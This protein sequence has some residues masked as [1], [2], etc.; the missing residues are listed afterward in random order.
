MAGTLQSPSQIKNVYDKLVF[1]TS[2][3]DADTHEIYMTDTALGQDQQIKSLDINHKQLYSVSH[4][5]QLEGPTLAFNMNQSTV[6]QTP[7]GAIDSTRGL[8]IPLN[9]TIIKAAIS[10]E[11]AV[12]NAGSWVD[13]GI[14]VWDNTN[15]GENHLHANVNKGYERLNLETPGNDLDSYNQV[16]FDPVSSLTLDSN[17]FYRGNSI[18]CWWLFENVDL[19]LDFHLLTRMSVL[20]E[21]DA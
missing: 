9:G 8:F 14:S 10:I 1:T 11:G 13:F 2:A 5:G 4:S 3:V 21:F 19:H 6:F 7:S 18:M 15:I 12:E 20:L 17:T 16:V